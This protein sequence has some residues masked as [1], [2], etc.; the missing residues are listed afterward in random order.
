MNT[1]DYILNTITKKYTD[2][3]IKPLTQNWIDACFILCNYHDLPKN[4]NLSFD[5][6]NR[7]LDVENDNNSPVLT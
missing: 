3:K 1:L 6:I 4:V 5:Y 7:V 2:M